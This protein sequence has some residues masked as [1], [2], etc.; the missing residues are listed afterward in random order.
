[1]P[2]PEEE[3]K[4]LKQQNSKLSRELRITQNFLVNVTRTVE[5]K[6]ALGQA[7]AADNAK[8]KAYTDM[9]LENCPNIILLFDDE[10]RLVLGTRMFLTLTGTPNIDYLRNRTYYDIFTPFLGADE[11]EELKILVETLKATQKTQNINKWMD[12]SKSGENRFYSINFMNI[13]SA[14]GE[15]AGIHAGIMMVFIDLTDFMREKQR[16]ETANNA[17]SDFLA[18]MSHE[19]RTPMNAILGL[20]EILART[21]LN[22]EQS[23]HLRDMK[24]SAHSLLT[25]INDI[26]DFSKIEAGKLDIIN[27]NFNLRALLDNLNSMFI[28]LYRGKNL[29]LNFSIDPN[30]PDIVYCDENRTRQVLTN[31]L[32]NALKYTREGCVEFSAFLDT[33]NSKDPPVHTL[34]FDIKDTGIGIRKEDMEKL[35]KPFEQLD[36]RKNRNIIGTGLGLAICYRLCRLMGGDLWIES[37]YGTGSIFSVGLPYTPAAALTEESEEETLKEFSAAEA[38]I[39]VVDDIEINLDICA[40]M[41]ESFDI[42]PDLAQNGKTA[43]ELAGGNV[44]DIIFMDHMMPEMD[45]LETTRRIRASGGV[46]ATVPIIALTANV[47]NGAQQMFRENQFSDFLAKPVEFESLNRCLRKWLPPQKIR[48]HGEK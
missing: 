36:I 35:F 16:A 12:F 47:I 44:Y 15:G 5:A 11:L 43:L 32:S 13:E 8:Q 14:K 10:E 37:E 31:L 4:E 9:L 17:K 3:I 38:R 41:L 29:A 2:S 33:D 6:E 20:N 40:A 7:L 23:K 1:V 42:K 24:K 25:I 30:L 39:L 22:A 28:V 45:G 18:V 21:E 27:S 26:L 48:E 34:R 19:I 46:Y